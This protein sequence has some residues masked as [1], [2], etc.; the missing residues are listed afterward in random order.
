M[1]AADVPICTV[2]V[3][4]EDE[5]K[6][7]SVSKE[8]E[9]LPPTPENEKE[10]IKQKFLVEMP[11]DFYSFWS[12]CQSLSPDKPEGVL[13]L[14][15]LLIRCWFILMSMV[16]PWICLLSIYKDIRIS[17]NRLPVKPEQLQSAVSKLLTQIFFNRS[18][19]Q[20][21]LGRIYDIKQL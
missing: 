11:E 21:R 12:F 10:A 14:C 19:G 15:S 16:L 8:E 20:P 17:S 4:V 6:A 1:A 5:C 2:P 9:D 7:L 3:Q 18:V 13:H